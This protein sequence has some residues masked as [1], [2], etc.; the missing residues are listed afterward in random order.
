MSGC[1]V[2]SLFAVAH[3]SGVVLSNKILDLGRFDLMFL[4]ADGVS[5]PSCLCQREEVS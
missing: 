4:I 1:K 5:A 2:M 3:D